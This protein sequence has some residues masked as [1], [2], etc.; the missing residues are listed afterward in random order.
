MISQLYLKCL[1][2]ALILLWAVGAF[3][4]LS[5]SDSISFWGYVISAIFIYAVLSI[6]KEIHKK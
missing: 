1:G 4:L 3:V 5:F 6:E 2:I